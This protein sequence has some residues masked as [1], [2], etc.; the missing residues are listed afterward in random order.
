M[1]MFLYRIELADGCWYVGSTTDPKRR[2]R[3]HEKGKSK[4]AAWTKLHKPLSPIEDHFEYWEIPFVT[5]FQVEQMEDD[6][7]IA[8]QKKHGLNKVRGGYRVQCRNVKRNL[9]RHKARFVY[10]KQN[11]S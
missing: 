6:F 9:P 2:M 4:A 8:L 7:T 11:R 1:K 3:E 5:K 10:Y